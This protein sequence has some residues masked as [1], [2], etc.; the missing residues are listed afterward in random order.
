VDTVICQQFVKRVLKERVCE[1]MHISA[2][3]NESS[4]R[5][6]MRIQA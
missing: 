1:Y 3:Y 2:V 4:E 5:Q 6:G